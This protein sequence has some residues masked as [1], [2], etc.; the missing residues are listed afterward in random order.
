MLKKKLYYSI[1]DIV[2]IQIQLRSYWNVEHHMAHGGNY[3]N[4][5]NLS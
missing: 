1:D 3:G 2:F 5:E 4:P